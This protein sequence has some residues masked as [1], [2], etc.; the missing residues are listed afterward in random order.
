MTTAAEW[1]LGPERR[2]VVLTGGEPLLQLTT[3]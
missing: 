1:G 2:F 3:N